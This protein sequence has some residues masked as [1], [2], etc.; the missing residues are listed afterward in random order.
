MFLYLHDIFSYS[1]RTEQF[2]TRMDIL[3]RE[4]AFSSRN[5]RRRFWNRGVPGAAMTSDPRDSFSSKTSFSSNFCKFN[6]KKALCP[7]LRKA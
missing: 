4:G 1:Y 3:P 5:C 7:N 2:A 6:K